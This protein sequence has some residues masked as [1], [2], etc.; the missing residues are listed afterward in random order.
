VLDFLRDA[1]TG[2]VVLFLGGVAIMQARSRW[3]FG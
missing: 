2:A 3:D 1:P